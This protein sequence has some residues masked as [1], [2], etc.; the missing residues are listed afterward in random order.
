MKKLIR[1]E[2][3]L[4][5]AVALVAVAAGWVG[6]ATAADGEKASAVTSVFKVEGMTCGGCEAGVKAKVKKLEGV[7]DVTASHKEGRATVTYDPEK[8]TPDAII[9]A[10]EE[11]GYSAELVR[12]A[13]QT[14]ETA[15]AAAEQSP[16][17]PRLTCC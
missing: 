12:D 4:F 13:S 11:L 1:P 7:R 8:V 6:Q 2:T 16:P 14:G 9:A 5:V 10:I 3:S 15:A 17:A